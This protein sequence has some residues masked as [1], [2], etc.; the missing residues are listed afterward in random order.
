MITTLEIR[1]LVQDYNSELYKLYTKE[2]YM[3][4]YIV[5]FGFNVGSE[6][7]CDFFLEQGISVS[8]IIDNNPAKHGCSYAGIQ[9]YS[10]DILKNTFRDNMLIFIASVYAPQMIKQIENMGYSAKKHVYCIKTFENEPK[11]NL[12]NKTEYRPLTI[13]EIQNITIKILDYVHYICTTNGLRYYIAYGSLLGAVRHK[14]PIPWD[15]DIDLLMPM[16]DYK[17]F[18][19]IMKNDNNYGLNCAFVNTCE[20]ASVNLIAQI[21]DLSTRALCKNFPLLIEGHIAIDIFPLGGYPSNKEEQIEYNSTLKKLGEDWNRSILRKI[22]TSGFSKNEY[23]NML[24]LMSEFM[25]KYDYETSEYLGSVACVPYGPLVMPRNS[26]D[27]VVSV[28]YGNNFYTAPSG[29]KEILKNRYGDYMQFP[30][31]SERRPGHFFDAYIKV[32]R[33]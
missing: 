21:M 25:E 14:G 29:W 2:E 10:P 30:P 17:K 20:V 32:E 18:L 27:N 22:H 9:V 19:E 8:A 28:Q 11:L 23:E 16:P 12:N 13:N 26:Y 24:K 33:N 6:M 1:N 7:I 4:R 31:E 5:L 3:Q 15:D